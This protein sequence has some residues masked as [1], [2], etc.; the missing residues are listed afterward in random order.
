MS[1]FGWDECFGSGAG[2]F[3]KTL[4]IAQE[5]CF[6][7]KLKKIDF[8]KVWKIVGIWKEKLEK[9]LSKKA[10]ELARGRVRGLFCLNFFPTFLSIFQQSFTPSKNQF[11]SIFRKNSPPALLTMFSWSLPLHFQNIRLNRT[12]TLKATMR[13]SRFFT[14][15]I[16]SASHFLVS[17][18]SASVA[19]A[20]ASRNA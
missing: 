10:P 8:W 5:G 16:F 13:L 7:E 14:C 6:F 1:E 17:R 2:G 4:L 12:L 15:Y 3:K 18:L 20:K 11:F 9:N 19:P